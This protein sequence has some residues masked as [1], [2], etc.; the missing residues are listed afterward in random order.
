[1]IARLPRQG[2]K[3]RIRALMHRAIPVATLLVLAG[4]GHKIGDSCGQNVD[5]SP[6]GDRF[7]DIASP[8]GYCTVEGCDISFVVATKSCSVD[9]NCDS[10]Q[11]CRNGQ[12]GTF[13]DSCPSEAVCIRFFQVINVRA[14]GKPASCTPVTAG[15]DCLPSE[16]CLCDCEDPNSPGNCLTPSMTTDANGVTTTSCTSGGTP[17]PIVAHCAPESSER[18][19]C[20]L[21]CNSNSDCRSPGYQC[22]QTGQFGA[23]PVPTTGFS[24]QPD[25]GT[26]AGVF[27]PTGTPVKYCAPIAT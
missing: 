4:C 16:R 11:N 21:T 2:S 7:C 27:I 18:R 25:G 15:T 6:L 5:C 14:D 24:A 9:S 17:S 1:M 3:A 26:G 13:V 23:E 8:G 19:T 20:Q 10:G 12:C 22:R